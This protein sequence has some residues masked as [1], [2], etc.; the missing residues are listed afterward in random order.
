M[1]LILL[2]WEA[3]KRTLVNAFGLLHP[4]QCVT[5]QCVIADEPII[6]QHAFLSV[7]N[8]VSGTVAGKGYLYYTSADRELWTASL[9]AVPGIVVV[10]STL[11]AVTAEV[12]IRVFDR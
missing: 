10:R 3:A 6:V 1:K 11:A 8:S 5:V 7:P 4:A 12:I 9:G 2:D